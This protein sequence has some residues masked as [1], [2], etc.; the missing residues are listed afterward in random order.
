MEE[1]VVEIPQYIRKIQLSAARLKKYYIK[2][3]REPK[4]EKYKDISRYAWK[5]EAGKEY[6]IDLSTGE[7][8]IANPK[9]QG[10]PNILAING[11]GIYNGKISSHTRNKMMMEIKKSFSSYINKL[12]PITE[13]PVN[14]YMEVH[15]TVLNDEKADWD[16]DNRS[17]PYI[18]AFQDCL[19]GNMDGEGKKRCKQ[20]IPDDNIMYITQPPAPKFIPVDKP[21]DRKLVFRIKKEEDDRVLKHVEYLTQLKKIINNE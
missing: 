13:F 9:A 10:T 2:G 16:L 15:D 19:M 21:E 12:D 18:K 4:A 20:I 5:K 11:Q 8:V 14:I 6:L 3:K 7:K 17:G 1:I